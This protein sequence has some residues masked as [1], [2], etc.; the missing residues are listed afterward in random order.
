MEELSKKKADLIYDQIDKSGGFYN[1]PVEKESR[2]LMNIVFRLPSEELDGKFVKEAEKE[3]MI[4]LKGH[5]DVGGCR[6]SLYNAMTV[7][8]ASV[9]A[10][11]M[12]NFAAANG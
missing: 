3:G 5:R 9:L 4:G 11:F 6:A 10:Q 2:S 8:G 12:N 1:C 7:E